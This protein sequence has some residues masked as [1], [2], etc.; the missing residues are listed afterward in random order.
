M[1]IGATRTVGGIVMAFLPSEDMRS[2]VMFELKM[3]ASVFGIIAIGLWLY[4]RSRARLPT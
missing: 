4:W 2:V 3:I 1:I